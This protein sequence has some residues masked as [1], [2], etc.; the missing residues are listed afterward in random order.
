M[1][2]ENSPVALECFRKA[3]SCDKKDYRIWLAI[4]DYY[5]FRKEYN[6]A[7]VHYQHCAE[8]FP[9][10]INAYCRLIRTLDN[11]KKY[12]LVQQVLTRAL[13]IDKENPEV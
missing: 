6:Q 13:S 8:L 11:L 10:C 5:S 1:Q 4:G 9:S 3:L 7:S 2:Q 12:K